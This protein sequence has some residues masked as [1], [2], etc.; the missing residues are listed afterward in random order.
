VFVACTRKKNVDMLDE[1]SH[2]MMGNPNDLEILS[3][4]LMGSQ[5]PEYMNQLAGIG[6]LM[7]QGG[8]PYLAALQQ[9]AAQQAMMGA[10]M[11]HMKGAPNPGLMGFSL[12]PFHYLAAGAGALGTGL[13]N[14]LH[15][16]LPWYHPGS[17]QHPAY[18][19]PMAAAPTP[20]QQLVAPIPGASARGTK[21]QPLGFEP[22]A[23]TAGSPTTIIV[24]AHPERPFRG[25]RLMSDI[26]R[27]GASATG[28]ITLSQLLVG[29]DGQLL[30]ADGIGLGTL[31]PTAFG[32]G[33]NLTP[34]A[35][36]QTIAATLTYTGPAIAGTDSVQVALT[37]YGLSIG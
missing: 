10:L 35:V 25:G 23:F 32:A 16:H 22:G 12:N 36:G 11:G 31:A 8:N 27:N 19:G 24:R 37:A 3:G 34:C 5:P 15:G 29:T 20:V 28:L 14:V 30:S 9:A 26:S 17:P 6:A 2:A 21:V 7:G 1:E 4:A 33:V 13:S 18:P